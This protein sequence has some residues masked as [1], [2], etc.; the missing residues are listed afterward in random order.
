M[1]VMMMV[2]VHKGK[3]LLN[4]SCLASGDLFSHGLIYR[5]NQA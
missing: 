4:G 2:V 3:L 5:R 1:M